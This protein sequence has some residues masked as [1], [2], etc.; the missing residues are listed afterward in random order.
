VFTA[1]GKL[2]VSVVQEGLIRPVRDPA[3]R[4]S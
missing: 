3:D 4:R 1:A 2:V